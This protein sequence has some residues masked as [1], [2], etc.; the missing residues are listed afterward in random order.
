[1]KTVNKILVG[2]ALDKLKKLDDGFIDCCITSPLYWSTK[3][4]IKTE[5][6]SWSSADGGEP[7]IGELGLEPT[8]DMYIEHLIQIFDEVRRVL[9]K[10]GS[11]W[12][13]MGDSYENKSI[14]M[15]P[16]QFAISMLNHNWI[17]RSKIIWHK[18]NK[19]LRHTIKDRFNLDWEYVFHFTK[20]KRYY[21]VQQH[22]QLPNDDNQIKGSVW[23][24]PLTPKAKHYMFEAFPCELI[25]TP[26][27]A[28]CPKN[29]IVLDPFIGS[30]TTGVMARNLGRDFL[31][32]ELAQVSADIALKRIKGH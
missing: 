22:E 12:V 31:G 32:I 13:V 20:N 9:K 8:L 21:F 6:Q 7:W 27:L 19:R 15:V 29:G 17:L 2:S 18:S 24:I 14:R 10:E 28:T 1:M 3:A 16:E 30:G 4:H 25:R 26:I 5:P 23:N 11:C